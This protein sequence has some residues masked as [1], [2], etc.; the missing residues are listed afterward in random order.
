MLP[1]ATH[2]RRLGLGSNGLGS[3]S[4][5]HLATSLARRPVQ[6]LEYLDLSRNNIGA[7]EA[8]DFAPARARR[9]T[10]D[11]EAGVEQHPARRGMLL[12]ALAY[13]STVVRAGWPSPPSSEAHPQRAYHAPCPRPRTVASTQTEVDLSFNGIGRKLPERNE[14][15]D[16]GEA[17]RARRC[18]SAR[19]RCDAP[20]RGPP[21][22]PHADL[23]T[24]IQRDSDL[25]LV[26]VDGLKRNTTL[27]RLGVQGNPIGEAAV[28]ALMRALETPIIRRSTR[29]TASSTSLTIRY[30]IR[31]ARR[32]PFLAAVRPVGGNGATRPRTQM[33][34]TS[35]R[36]TTTPHPTRRGVGTSGCEKLID[37]NS[38]TLDVSM[39]GITLDGKAAERKAFKSARDLPT[40]DCFS[41]TSPC[42]RARRRSR[43]AA[44][45]SSA[46][47]APCWSSR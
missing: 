12:H 37:A 11:V 24:S 19:V 32:A 18:D 26:M 4:V 14:P 8:D 44:T 5:G 28:H 30:L 38:I 20:R 29:Q 40:T 22:E 2:L 9:R 13:N 15:R 46:S 3:S 23:S 6:T 10:A 45:C 16:N 47:Y 31:R 39:R 34:D 27:L 1:H 35:Q 17:T 21:R 36:H 41:S 33:H 42:S 25:C 43:R 7:E